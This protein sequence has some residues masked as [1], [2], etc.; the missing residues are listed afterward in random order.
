MPS[1]D[2]WEGH[3]PIGIESTINFAPTLWA[4]KL[5]IL[6][7]RVGEEEQEIQ[8]VLGSFG[9]LLSSPVWL[10]GGRFSLIPPLYK[11]PQ[12]P[13]PF[14]CLVFNFDSFSTLHKMFN[15]RSMP[16]LGDDFRQRLNLLGITAK[17]SYDRL[18]HLNSQ[19]RPA[20]YVDTLSAA[21]DALYSFV[22]DSEQWGRKAMAIR[23]DLAAAPVLSLAI[24]MDPVYGMVDFVTIAT[25]SGE[26]ATLSMADLRRN[27]GPHF[28][29]KDVIPEELRYW[30]CSD[31][32]LILVSGQSHLFK[33]PPPGLTTTA[34]VD[35]DELFELYMEK[36]VIRPNLP[37][38]KGDITYQM[39][40]AF[41]WHHRPTSQEKFKLMVGEHN[42]DKWPRH[43]ELGWRPQ[44]HERQPSKT[45]RFS[46]FCD[47]NGPLGFVYRLLRH[48]LTYGG[49]LAVQPELELGQ[50]IAV[51]LRANLGG[52]RTVGRGSA[53][54]LGLQSDR[55]LED[56]EVT[57]A[58]AA[59]PPTPP[60]RPFDP[61]SPTQE[62]PEPRLVIDYS[63]PEYE[64]ELH[65][66]D[67]EQ[68]LRRE[69][70][71][72]NPVIEGME[73]GE[74]EPPGVEARPTSSPPQT[75]EGRRERRGRPP[76]PG[77][78]RDAEATVQVYQVDES[79]ARVRRMPGERTASAPGRSILREC[80]GFRPDPPA[81]PV[82][83]EV[84]FL[85]EVVTISST[86][87]SP[88]N[89]N[90]RNRLEST[91]VSP[92][93]A[94]ANKKRIL[95][96]RSA[97]EG[98]AHC[99]AAAPSATRPS[100]ST[101]GGSARQA[102]AAP[103]VVRPSASVSARSCSGTASTARSTAT[104][105]TAAGTGA[106]RRRLASPP[107]SRSGA[108]RTGR[109]A[110]ASRATSSSAVVRSA[111]AT[112]SARGR[113][114][115]RLAPVIRSA[116]RSTSAPGRRASPS[117]TVTSA[118]TSRATPP[119][120]SKA[121]A[122]R[123]AP[124]ATVTSAS[125]RAATTAPASASSASSSST[126]SGYSAKAPPAAASR[127]PGREREGDVGPQP[128]TS[129]GIFEPFPPQER[130]SVLARTH[131]TADVRTRLALLA[132]AQAFS[133]SNEYSPH[134]DYV[135]PDI[136]IMHRMKLLAKL[137]KDP[138]LLKL[139]GGWENDAG[140][141]A[142]M[143]GPLKYRMES[144][145][146]RTWKKRGDICM[147]VPIYCIYAMLIDEKNIALRHMCEFFVWGREKEI[148][149]SDWFGTWRCVDVL[150]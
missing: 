34:Y 125:L 103:P 86:E 16:L 129:K 70:M 13:L 100:A 37:P 88:E 56:M 143:I 5:V 46:F 74:P 101:S 26:T 148:K 49:M 123:P 30:L 140:F 47:V 1:S 69:A 150:F 75:P 89:E 136:N 11:R 22:V 73:V 44:C 126:P 67:I 97:P 43:R 14:S 25:Y 85:Q 12:G 124:S 65:D 45:E 58:G 52:C 33:D 102:A 2:T 128:S 10:L 121:S 76:G 71:E 118:A 113:V 60:Y 149:C 114:W 130:P 116:P 35:A 104:T 139:T 145:T 108:T 135:R 62:S 19:I 7:G 54:P 64:L 87:N 72:E 39:T 120:A 92:S 78:Y 20:P 138:F 131:S 94:S 27:C 105:S 41:D 28:Q 50:L 6:I 4:T 9:V 61:S 122:G 99:T 55:E 29:E 146:G 127:S 109:P 142:A 80:E 53:D 90:E 93:P 51:F 83:R 110:P 36:G 119:P 134:Q 18:R 81:T 32:V 3:R 106:V 38:R 21:Q 96:T 8:L 137:D 68:E 132:S 66:D 144:N 79:P 141:D 57:G 111:S 115:S 40:Y 77:F 17:A 23:C 147:C 48:G 31:R 82:R 133:G 59:P 107:A 98:S 15:P 84:T 24:Q 63:S 95:S 112:G 91:S 42:Y 117:A